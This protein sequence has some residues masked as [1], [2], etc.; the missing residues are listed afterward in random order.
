MGA[1]VALVFIC[2]AVSKSAAATAG[3][4]GLT[5]PYQNT[6]F[7]PNPAHPWNRLYG[8]L[9]IRPAWDGKLYGADEMDPLYWPDSKYLL[10]Q[11]LHRQVIQALDQFVHSDSAHLISDPLKRA[12]LQRMLWALFDT[13]A[14]HEN[15]AYHS[16][17][18]DTERKEIQLRLVS[19][20]KAVALTNA[21]IK[22]LPDNYTSEVEA[23]S[24]PAAFDPARETQPFLPAAFSPRSNLVDL[25]DHSYPGF[26]PI[27]PIHVAGVSG[28]S[29]FH[30]LIGLPSGKSD[31]LAYL[32]KINAFEPHWIYD[33]MRQSGTNEELAPQINPALPQVP[34]LTTL[35]LVRKANLINNEGEPVNSPLTETVRLR[36]I[37][38]LSYYGDTPSQTPFLFILDQAKLLKGQGGLVAQRKEPGFDMVLNKLFAISGDSLERRY[39]ENASPGGEMLLTSCLQCHSSGPGIFS[40]NSYNQSFSAPK[41][42]TPNLQEGESAGSDSINWKKHQY[43]W[44]LLKAY[45]F[46]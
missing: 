29:A 13:L 11:P 26:G 46:R 40:M 16:D 24:Y 43:D 19:I 32:K 3:P 30:I 5:P 36:V 14:A 9:F 37:R 8:M 27:A 44:G 2:I 45:W 7:D 38:S 6:F 20:M 33:M 34:P 25:E 35:A 23:K 22:S 18:F 28:R 12:L 21:E 31:T 10:T 42:R 15:D 4:Q 17:H 39:G 1:F 41:L